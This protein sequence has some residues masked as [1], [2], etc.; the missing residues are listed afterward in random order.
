MAEP[1]GMVFYEGSAFFVYLRHVLTDL[2]IPM[3]AERGGPLAA[4]KFQLRTP[5]LRFPRGSGGAGRRESYE[6]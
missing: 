3:V 1:Y 2:I 5:R 6:I 4:C